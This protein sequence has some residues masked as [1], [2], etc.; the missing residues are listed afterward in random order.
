MFAIFPKNMHHGTSLKFPASR[1]EKPKED[2]STI[3]QESLTDSDLDFFFFLTK[4]NPWATSLK[5][6]PP[7]KH[8]VLCTKYPSREG[9]V[10]QGLSRDK[11]L[12]QNIRAPTGTTHQLTFYS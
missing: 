10:I 9:P 11:K 12:R 2:F 7:G 8:V 5:T 1:G 4:Q 6:A 3:M